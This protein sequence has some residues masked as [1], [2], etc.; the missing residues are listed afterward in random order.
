M[1][2]IILVI[3]ITV[4][5]LLIIVITLLV[6]LLRKKVKVELSDE[7]K[8][9]NSETLT[10]LNFV[11]GRINELRG[12]LEQAFQKRFGEQ[13]EKLNENDAK[14]V[15]TIREDIEGKLDKLNEEVQKKLKD[16]SEISKKTFEDM[17][18][19][20]KALDEAFKGL[21][22]FSGEV[23]DLTRIISGENQKRGKF[24][25]FV[26]ESILD[27]VFA[28]TTNLYSTQHSFN[29]VRPDAVIYLPRHDNNILCIDAKFPYTNYESIFNADGEVMPSGKK[30]FADDIKKKIDEVKNKYIVKNVTIDY[31]LCFF[32]S[33]EIFHYI[34]AEEQNLVK[35]A[36][37]NNVVLVSPSTLQP[38]LHT[39]KSLMIEYNRSKKLAEVN[40]LIVS[41]ATDFDIVGKRWDNLV[42]QLNTLNVTTTDLDK[43]LNRLSN[44]FENIK[45]EGEIKDE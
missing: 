1:D 29:G 23:K 34:N 38:T 24:G 8:V 27:E 40:A 25:E 17:G 32:P 41:L 3:L 33:D 28:G 11:Q 20:L 12:E 31:A 22:A 5:V 45:N 7:V 43:T 21:E 18:A 37:K 30:V 9:D 44:K 2:D 26:L 39:L 13:T 15:K 16:D 10:Q 35:Y 42:K 19:K 36:R 4:A 14:F 6:V